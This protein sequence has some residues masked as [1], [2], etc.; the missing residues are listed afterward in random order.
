M[1]YTYCLRNFLY[2]IHSYYGSYTQEQSVKRKNRE[3]NYKA[4][5]TAIREMSSVVL[6]TEYVSPL[7]G[8]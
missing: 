8:F 5:S 2:K 6:M 3:H 1:T 7:D 4:P